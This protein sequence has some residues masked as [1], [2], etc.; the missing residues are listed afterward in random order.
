MLT[1]TLPTLDARKQR[2]LRYDLRV[3]ATFIRIY[4][5]GHHAGQA[6][7]PVPEPIWRLAQTGRPPPSLCPVC[8]KLLGHAAAKRR[9]C[10]FDPK[11]ACKHCPDHCYLPAY[12]TQIRE[13]MRYSGRRLVLSGRLDYLWRLLF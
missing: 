4:C 11:P 12:R 13:V 6:R 5:D 8:T 10:P 1:R 3:L 2:K 7:A 9:A